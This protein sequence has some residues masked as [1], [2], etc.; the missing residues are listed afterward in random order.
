[1]ARS[2]ATRRARWGC[3]ARERDRT[4]VSWQVGHLAGHPP[5]AARTASRA[6]SGIQAP[7]K[8][9][10]RAG[11]ALAPAG[12]PIPA[13]SPA[14]APAIE[15]AAATTDPGRV[16]SVPT[17]RPRLP[18]AERGGIRGEQP[19]ER[20]VGGPYVDGTGTARRGRDR[21]RRGGC[22][23]ACRGTAQARRRT[24]R[25]APSAARWPGW[26]LDLVRARRDGAGLPDY[27]RLP[28]DRSWCRRALL[29]G[30]PARIRPVGGCQR[31]QPPLRRGVRGLRESVRARMRDP[32]RMRVG[33]RG[34]G[35]QLRLSVTLQP[36]YV[37][38]TLS[39]FRMP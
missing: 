22:R 1:M 5:G 11:G 7:S 29:S 2:G 33:R 17:P 30:L 15:T 34:T 20:G 37:C 35:R 39:A 26:A 21:L 25:D 13:R 31:R 27:G 38:D 12:V 6:V 8:S 18:A 10:E 14:G 32:P 19:V 28:G 3:C 23:G 24:H 36:V 9:D 4:S 16:A